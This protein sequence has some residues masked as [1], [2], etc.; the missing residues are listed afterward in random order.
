MGLGA[1]AVVVARKG[2]RRPA[3]RAKINSHDRFV[4]D[5]IASLGYDWERV[6]V[7]GISARPPRKVYM[8][9][10]T[11]DVV[12]AVQEA[13]RFGEVLRVRGNGHSS[14]DLVLGDR[15]SVLLTRRLNRI[16]GLDEA[17]GEASVEAGVITAELDDY[18]ADRGFGLPVIG[19]HIHITA[20]GF[21]SVGGVGGAS[22]RYGLFVDNVNWLEYVDWD[23]AVHRCSASEDADRFYAVLCGQGQ[24]GVI[25][26]LGCKV[27]PIDKYRTILRNDESYFRDLGRFLEAND[28][29]MKASEESAM[30]RGVW[31]E[32]FPSPKRRIEFGLL[33]VYRD[34]GQSGYRR[35]RNAAAYGLLHRVGAVAGKLPARVDRAL[36]YVGTA[37]MIF[38]PRYASIKN[39]EVFTDKT[40]DYTVGDPNRWMIAWSPDAHYREAFEKLW[41][42]LTRVQKETSCFTA[43]ACDFRPIRSGYLGRGGPDLFCEL[44]FYLQTKPEAMT[45]ALFEQLLSEFDDI[46]IETSTFRYMQTKTVSDTERRRRLDANSHYADRARPGAGAPRG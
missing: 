44:L 25:T 3:W 9:N 45:P 2:S 4:H 31:T 11:E 30:G 36:K 46:C 37:G 18:L 23:G 13:R 27:I 39:V 15:N 12:R 7:P 28:A 5:S 26:R 34:L 42:L 21:A 17:A 32:V 43:I 6:A 10:S 20:A 22:H 35:L 1:A 29:Y 40:I 33:S 41:A 14:N 38:S 19:D 16:V 24:A 8:P